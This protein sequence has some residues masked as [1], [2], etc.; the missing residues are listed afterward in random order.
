MPSPQKSPSKYVTPEREKLKEEPY[1]RKTP[2][3]SQ[4]SLSNLNTKEFTSPSKLNIKPMD[5]ILEEDPHSPKV[6][7]HIGKKIQN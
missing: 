6:E 3:E 5:S 4:L 1:L 2:S 7:Q